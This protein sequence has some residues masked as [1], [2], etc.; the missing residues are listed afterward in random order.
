[1][2]TSSDHTLSKEKMRQ[3]IDF[4]C[5]TMID[6]TTSWLKILELLVV[7]TPAIP[8]GKQG[9]K[10]TSTYTT[11]KVPYFDKSSA[12]IST[13]ANK[14][15][16]SWYPHCQQV[17]YDNGSEFKL[18]FEAICDTYGIKHKPTSVKNRQANAI[19]EHVHQ[20]IMAI[21]HTAEIDMAD[22]V[23]ASDIDTFLTN[24]AW[25]IC[26]TYHTGLKASP[27]AAS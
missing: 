24:V 23:A 21:L 10:G 4:M 9:R 15:W 7:E 16:F 5:L 27:G 17:N 22:S 2:W 11:P 20:V 25:A 12:M 18:C 1:M 14:T 8:I 3:K 6:P 19:L 13:L 26:S